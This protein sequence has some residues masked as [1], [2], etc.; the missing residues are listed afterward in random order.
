MIFIMEV[1]DLV[2]IGGKNKLSDFLKLWVKDMWDFTKTFMFL[3]GLLV[4]GLAIHIGAW[5]MIFQTLS[6][7]VIWSL[8]ATLIEK[9]L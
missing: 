8:V 3:I 7:I 2:F 4:V 1:L 6:I 9:F 5:T